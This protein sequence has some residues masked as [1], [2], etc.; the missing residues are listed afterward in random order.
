[1]TYPVVRTFNLYVGIGYL[2][3]DSFTLC[4]IVEQYSEIEE[5]IT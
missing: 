4:R 1:M 2:K 3:F 5:S